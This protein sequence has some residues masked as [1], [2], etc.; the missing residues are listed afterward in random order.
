[1]DSVLGK[2]AFQMAVEGKLKMLEIEDLR[3]AAALV[4]ALIEIREAVEEG[5][6]KLAMGQLVV[7][8][9]IADAIRENTAVQKAIADRAGT[10]EEQGVEMLKGF[11]EIREDLQAQRAVVTELL[12]TAGQYAARLDQHEH[13]LTAH[14]GLIAGLAEEKQDRPEVLNGPDTARAGG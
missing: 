9:E 3:V 7:A 12:A 10:I 14:K 8:K 5:F 4:V 6:G 1:M 13:W 11:D 2:D